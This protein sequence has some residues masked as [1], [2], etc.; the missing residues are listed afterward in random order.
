MKF[1]IVTISYNQSPFLEQ[2]ILSVITQ[3]YYDIEYIIVDAGSTDGSRKIIEKYSNYFSQIIF[4]PDFGPPDG[5][6]KGFLKATGEIFAALNADDMF[7][8][9]AI[10]DVANYFA[11]NPDVDIVSGHSIIIDQFNNTIRKSYS[12]K[13]NPVMYAYGTAELMQPSTFIRKNC[14]L[15]VNGYNT[16]NLSNWDSEIFIDM[17]QTGAKFGLANK[18]FSYYRLHPDSITSSK[19]LDHKIKNY[20]NY[21]FKK[22][23]GRDIRGFDNVIRFILLLVK[24]SKNFR[25]LMERLQNGKIYGRVTN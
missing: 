14:Y 9:G 11:S 8:A 15:K 2:T 24:Y 18:F 25:S 4:E 5:L 1:S 16:K 20:Y 19:K 17:Y 21:R 22:M 23:T 7:T 6:N 10:G 13:F 12:D 3:N